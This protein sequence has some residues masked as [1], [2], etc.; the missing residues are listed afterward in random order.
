MKRV[1]VTCAGSGVAQSVIDSLKFTKEKYHVLASDQ[2]RYCYSLPDCDG[3]VTLPNICE[4]TYV[5]AVLEECKRL[6]IQALIPGHDLELALFAGASAHFEAVGT[7][8]IVSDL[9]LVELL[10]DKLAWA[11]EFRQRGASVVESFSAGSLRNDPAVETFSFPAIAKPVGGSASAG[12]RI[13]Q[14]VKDLYAVPDEFVIQPYLFPGDDDP[15]AAFIRSAVQG[16]HV[17]QLSEISVQLVFSRDYRLL[18][19]FAS[20]NRLKSGVPVEIRPIDSSEVWA[21]VDEIVKVLSEYGPRGPINLQGRMTSSGLVFFE[22]NPRFTGITGNRA[23]FGFNEVSLLIDNFTEGT[24]RELFTN[25]RKVGVRQVSCRTWPSERFMFNACSMKRGETK[26]IV[27]TGG[28]GW[29]ARNFAAS[30]AAMGDHVIISCRKQSVERAS[31]IYREYRNIRVFVLDAEEIKDAMA[32][33]DVLVNLASARPPHGAALIVDSYKYQLRVLD[34]AAVCDIPKIVNV[35]SKSVYDAN[36]CAHM[37]EDAEIS[38]K[39]PY[40]FSKYAIELSL[41]SLVWRRPSINAVS[42]RIARLFGVAPGMRS[43]EFPHR[44]VSS[45]LN[46]TEISIRNPGD[47]LDLLDIRDAVSAISF[48]VDREAT[49]LRGTVFNVGTGNPIT[50]A[51]YVALVD[52]IAHDRYGRGL[53]LSKPVDDVG[54]RSSSAIDC[55]KL[56]EAG[57]SSEIDVRE[58]ILRLFEHYSDEIR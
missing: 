21:A 42:F 28:T 8:V 39:E 4:P 50:V 53:Q 31:E 16:R 58:S 35:S 32:S 30:R 55:S 10:R 19:R 33:A 23:Q 56:A 38:V 14:N 51:G 43:T 11:R 9:R 7:A 3:F 52:Q 18:A 1:L 46:G 20:R 48:A 34:L 57:W 5:D 41:G 36:E 37:T 15:E 45:A 24:E 2:N 25:L 54:V 40:G 22:M 49:D 12:V 29:L 27:V 13:L 47:V 44:V 6:S 17:V 26:T